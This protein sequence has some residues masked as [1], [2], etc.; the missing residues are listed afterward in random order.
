MVGD[1][2][3]NLAANPVGQDAICLITLGASFYGG[4]ERLDNDLRALADCVVITDDIAGVDQ[5]G[6]LDVAARDKAAVVVMPPRRRLV[7]AGELEI[8]RPQSGQALP[9]F[10][11]WSPHAAHCAMPQGQSHGDPAPTLGSPLQPPRCGCA[12]C[13]SRGQRVRIGVG[14]GRC[15]RAQICWTFVLRRY[16]S[17]SIPSAV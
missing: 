13:E 1:G 4:L 10:R 6:I 11:D 5:V 9:P 8:R 2:S 14:L 12:P 16:N 15:S 17:D 7:R 3:A